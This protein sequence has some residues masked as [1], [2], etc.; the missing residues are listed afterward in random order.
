MDLREGQRNSAYQLMANELGISHVAV[1]C[2]YMGLQLAVSLV[3]VY[4]VPNT[5]LAN[6]I[7]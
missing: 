5:P 3:M 6:W 7:T 2:I 1:S 4:L